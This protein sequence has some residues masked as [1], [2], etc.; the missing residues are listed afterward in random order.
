MIGEGE[1]EELAT[2]FRLL[3]DPNR[4]GVA[5]VCLEQERNVGAIAARLGLSLSL[6]SHHLGVLRNARLLRARKQGR[7]TF[8]RLADD[9]VRAMLSN[10]VAHVSHNDSDPP[11]NTSKG[12]DNG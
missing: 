3:G 11:A 4:L 12:S 9:H 7:Q 8:Y 10:M 6:A 1:R 5:L 2:M